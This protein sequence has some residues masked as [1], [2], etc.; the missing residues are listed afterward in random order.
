MISHFVL[1]LCISLE[2]S[3]HTRAPV[4]INIELLVF[5]FQQTNNPHYLI[6]KHQYITIFFFYFTGRRTLIMQLALDADST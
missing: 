1:T 6:T 2:I 3:I 5:I 4:F